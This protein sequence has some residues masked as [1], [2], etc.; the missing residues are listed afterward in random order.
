MKNIRTLNIILLTFIS[1]FSFGQNDSSS[2]DGNGF[3]SV[4]QNL[5]SGNFSGTI[6]GILI[7]KDLE[8]K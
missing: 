3:D 7:V 5:E 8:K 4:F 1:F 2:I 6:S